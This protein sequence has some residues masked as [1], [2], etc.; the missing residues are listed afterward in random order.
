MNF[1]L[2]N[3]IFYL[4]PNV[5][6]FLKNVFKR[7]IRAQF[8]VEKMK[9]EHFDVARTRKCAECGSDKEMRRLTLPRVKIRM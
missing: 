6:G 2:E 7:Q 4:C 9:D 3:Q 8:K 1:N 5:A